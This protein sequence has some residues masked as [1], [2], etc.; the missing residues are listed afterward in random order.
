MKVL[1]PFE[2]IGCRVGSKLTYARIG[3]MKGLMLYGEEPTLFKALKR[4]WG[5]RFDAQVFAEALRRA[6]VD[7][8]LLPA[9][10]KEEQ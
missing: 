1:G 9:Q 3:P 4:R 6:A 2:R 7:E 10:A 8:K 5:M